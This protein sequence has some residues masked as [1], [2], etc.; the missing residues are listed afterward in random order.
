MEGRGWEAESSQRE[1]DL[2]YERIARLH[3]R[4]EKRFLLNELT[5]QTL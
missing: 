1:I 4:T 2:K 5:V 3:V